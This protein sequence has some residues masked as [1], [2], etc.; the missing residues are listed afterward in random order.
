MYFCRV[1]THDF[2]TFNAVT[3]WAAVVNKKFSC[4]FCGLNHQVFHAGSILHTRFGPHMNKGRGC[5]RR[6]SEA[7]SFYGSVI[8]PDQVSSCTQHHLSRLSETQLSLPEYTPH[9]AFVP[10]R[11]FQV[12]SRL[13]GLR[14]WG[15][16]NMNNNTDEQKTDSTFPIIIDQAVRCAIDIEDPLYDASDCQC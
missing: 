11:C 1:H 7:P 2:D 5:L 10:P 13:Y 16:E 4:C 6:I 14:F 8:I 9:V 15:S 12:F 3:F